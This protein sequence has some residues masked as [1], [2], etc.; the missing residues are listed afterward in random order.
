MK[1]ALFN[2]HEITINDE[3]VLI[4]FY[5]GDIFDV[6]SD[7]LLLSAFKDNYYPVPGTTW[8][9]LHERTG[10]AVNTDECCQ[11]NISENLIHFQ[12]PENECFSELA[13]LEL[14]DLKQPKKFTIG[15]LK[16][17][18]RELIHFL[19]NHP[20][21]QGESISLPLLG[22]GRQGIS[23]EQ[24]V[25]E[26][27][28]TF[29]KL[30]KTRLKVIRVFAWDF[31]SI[32]VLN[33]KINEQLKRTE[34]VHT[35]LLNEAMNEARKMLRGKISQLS[36]D[37]IT[38]LISLNDSNHA[39]FFSFGLKGRIYAEKVCAELLQLYAIELEQPCSLNLHIKGLSEK[40][41]QE[42]ATILSH[43]RLLQ[44]YGNK[45]AHGIG[46]DLDHQDAAAIVISIMKVVDFYEYKLGW[47]PD[48]SEI[49]EAD[50][51]CR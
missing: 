31:E 35:S 29:N 43:L 15:T 3:S 13:A 21:D 33:K 27:L 50:N 25:A 42:R 51:E 49:K 16:Q 20:S 30:R 9:S 28:N 18:Y 46:E 2:L 12:T 48:P 40:L 24:S 19:E 36:F 1:T 47:A 7:I 17:R 8:G 37:T 5:A 14:A 38:D 23:L 11:S 32:G 45:A 41:M 26:L 22:T 6:P 44:T 34:I 39:S 4:E 10:I